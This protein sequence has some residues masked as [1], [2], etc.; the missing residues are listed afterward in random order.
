MERARIMVTEAAAQRRQHF[1][2]VVGVEI[3]KEDEEDRQAG[4]GVE[5]GEK[6][7]RLAADVSSNPEQGE[8]KTQL[9]QTKPPL[10]PPRRRSYENYSISLE[11]ETEEQAQQRK[12]REEE[13]KTREE[14]QDR[15]R[16]EE[17]EEE[18]KRAYR[19]LDE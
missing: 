19:L 5:D 17:E 9:Q 10:S 7:L 1:I 12:V 6:L 16:E 11:E 14:E 4:E 15:E 2:N 18:R 3:G 8:G 13:K